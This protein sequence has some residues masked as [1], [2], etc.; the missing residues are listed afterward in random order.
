V[1]GRG[2]FRRDVDPVQFAEEILRALER[3]GE[4]AVCFVDARGQGLG[5]LLCG[6][7]WVF[8]WV[9]GALELEKFAA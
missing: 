8:V 6:A 5:V 9:D 1:L 2:I 7:G 3:V 4:C